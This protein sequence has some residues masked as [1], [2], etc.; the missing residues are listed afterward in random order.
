[1][2]P[3]PS[4]LPDYFAVVVEPLVRTHVPELA[5]LIERCRS[6]NRM[7]PGLWHSELGSEAAA[8]RTWERADADRRA[9]IGDTLIVRGPHETTIGCVFVSTFDWVHGACAISCC[10]DSSGRPVPQTAATLAAAVRWARAR[11]LTR[12][13]LVAKA[14]DSVT[15]Q[16][17]LAAGAHHEGVLR[18]RFLIEGRREDGFLYAFA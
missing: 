17:A 8:R 10:L 18:R 4:V 9:C 1:M 16:A 3:Q 11:G 14:S 13:E 7:L 15:Q 5:I 2:S 12:L 6:V